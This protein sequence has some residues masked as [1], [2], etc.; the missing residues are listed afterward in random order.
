MP[1]EAMPFRPIAMRQIIII[2]SILFEKGDLL[3]EHVNWAKWLL[4]Q[5]ALA[6]MAIGPNGIGPNGNGRN[7]IG[8]SGFWPKW[9]WPKWLLAKLGI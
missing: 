6:E 1:F 2:L 3:V 5:M 4:A 8:Q 7:G 9:H